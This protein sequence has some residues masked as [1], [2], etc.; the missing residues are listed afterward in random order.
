MRH[1][2]QLST[3]GLWLHFQTKFD[4]VP[5]TVEIR[6]DSRLFCKVDRN[7]SQQKVTDTPCIFYLCVWIFP[8]RY[9]TLSRHLI[10]SILVH[11]SPPPSLTSPDRSAWLIFSGSNVEAASLHAFLI[12]PLRFS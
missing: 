2:E 12:I 3:Q 7:K 9:G 5:C 10:P 4:Q 8:D 6:V 11:P 1:C